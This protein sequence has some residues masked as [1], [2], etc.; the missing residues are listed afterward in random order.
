MLE[1]PV[2]I[3][4]SLAYLGVLFAVAWWGDKRADAGRSIIA[5]PT[6]YALS[7]AVY[8][9]TWTFYGSVGRAA[10]SGI[11]FLPIYLGPTL[12]MALGGFLLLKMIRIVKANRITSI[13]DFISSRYGKSHL[14]GGLVTIIAVVGI[15]PYISLQLKA[16]TS[17]VS[18][19]L[20]YPDIVMPDHSTTMSLA[21]DVSLYVA[22]ILAAFTIVFG[23]RHL[24]ATERHEGMVAAIALES[25]VKLVAFL[26]V[27]IFVT[28]F[29]FNGFGDIFEHAESDA[30]LQRLMTA[31]PSGGGYTNWLSLMILSALAVLFLPRQFQVA[32]V[33]NVNETHVKRAAWLFPLYL[34]LINVFVLPIAFGGLLHFADQGVDADTF[35]LTLP[36]SQRHEGLTLLVFIGGLSAGTGMVIVETI[37]LSTM[38]CNDLIM[39]ILLRYKALG[40]EDG[41][42]LSFVL[43][44]IRRGAIVVILLLGYLYFRLAGEAYALVAIGLISFSA[45]AQFAP[46][47]IGGMYWRGGTRGGALAG[48]G[49]GFI[50]WTYT[51][52]LPSFA[53]SGWLPDDFLTHGLF[54]VEL[55]RPQQLFGLTGFDEISH[56]LFWSLLANI[57]AYT[58]FSLLRPPMAA[59]AAQA[60]VFVDALKGIGPVG[61]AFWRGRAQVSD[62]QGLVGRFLGPARAKTLFSAYAKRRGHADGV[63]SEADAQLVQF[64]ESLLAGAIGSASARVMV[65]SV[66]K[67]EPLSI[68]E[69]MHIL[70]EASQLRTYSRELERKSRELTAA[71]LELQEANERLQ[72]LDRVKDDI[73]SSVTHELRTP[74]TS[75]RAFSELLRDDPKMHLAD[76]ERFLGLIVSEAERLSRLINQTLDLAK[77]E[78]GRADWN[79]GELDL[80]EVIE[81]SVAATSELFREKGTFVELDLP[82]GMP[83]ILADRDRLIQVLLN[84]LSNA[85][86]FLTP[87][88]GRVRVSLRRVP[89]ALEVSVA[90][91][92]P[93]I[94]PEHQEVIFE[95]FRQVGDTMTAKPSGTGLGLPISRR[96]IEHLGGRL[97]VES[98]PGEG[99]TF[100]FTL[101]LAVVEEE[102]PLP[103]PIPAWGG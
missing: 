36:M 70:D 100:R 40:F 68:D 9:T 35:V 19:L 96:I 20:S 50:V 63:I 6:I 71:T 81:Q 61:A 84:L 62:L 75:I 24:D 10:V 76:R 42:D 92:G 8:C 12:V 77:I 25:A 103:E 101:P 30:G 72:E 56:C 98:V 58:G 89:G 11:G 65:A 91:N 38:V 59:E 28:Y 3:C 102:N 79:S 69:V 95:K 4:L 99:A 51:L 26:S 55:L 67:E 88:E 93:G 29:V 85:A 43:L 78:S 83:P 34:L 87:N 90:D 53:K 49:A 54:G 32:V 39:P 46:A 45:V 33:E 2:V 37:A 47:M 1:A 13:A 97:W 18:L 74:L 21:E 23:T 48:L 14:L 86:K 64:A 80:S 60:S 41:R 7:M 15:I 31:I 73:M 5:S 17:S 44:G 94:R 52:L 82:E 27:G 66:A 16:V 57:G 22:L